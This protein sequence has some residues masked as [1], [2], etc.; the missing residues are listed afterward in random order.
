MREALPCAVLLARGG[1]LGYLGYR[2]VWPIRVG[3]LSRSGVARFA[4]VPM[5]ASR[6]VPEVRSRCACRISPAILRMSSSAIAPIPRLSRASTLAPRP[7]GHPHGACPR[8]CA[9][10][11]SECA[12]EIGEYTP[13]QIKQAVVGTGAADKRQVAYMVRTLTQLDHDPH[14]DHAADAL[15]CAICHVNLSRT[16]RLPAASSIN[17][18]EPDTDD[19]PAPRNACRG[20]DELCCRRCVG[21]WL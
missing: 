6:P 14:P 4:V 8:C 12:L 10:A 15:A 7:L 21:R 2:L 5:A 9:R 11:L 18:E 1:R 3:G 16:R 13:M 20:H 17:R 19:F